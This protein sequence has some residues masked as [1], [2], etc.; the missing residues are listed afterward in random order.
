[1]KARPKT[2]LIAILAAT[3]LAACASPFSSW[4]W[5]KPDGDYDTDVAACKT[6]SYADSNGALPTNASVRRMQ[7]CMEGKGWKKVVR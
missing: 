2:T 7:S 5:E 6:A 1:M 3:T 4:R